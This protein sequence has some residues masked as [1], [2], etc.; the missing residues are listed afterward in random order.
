VFLISFFNFFRQNYF[1]YF[2]P[3]FNFSYI[4]WILFDISFLTFSD[5]ISIRCFPSNFFVLS[6]MT[7]LIQSLLLTFEMYF[8]FHFFVDVNLISSFRLFP[9]NCQT[10]AR[11]ST[12]T[13]TTCWQTQEPP[14]SKSGREKFWIRSDF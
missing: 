6:Y 3:D 7:P 10:F 2:L 13:T 14:A 4:I 5:Q 12:C 11:S 1:F 9:S 8:T